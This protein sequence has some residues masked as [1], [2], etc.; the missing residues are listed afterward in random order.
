MNRK[1]YLTS[2]LLRRGA[3]PLSAWRV[4]L[5]ATAALV[6]SVSATPAASGQNRPNIAN[7]VEGVEKPKGGAPGNSKPGGEARKQ[8]T[9]RPAPGPRPTSPRQ[10][11]TLSVTFVTGQP[12]S[13]IYLRRD[14]SRLYRLG[15]TGPDGKLVTRLA[16]GPHDV[17]AS[18]LGYGMQ[19]QQVEVRPGSTTFTFNLS[20]ASTGG[21]GVAVGASVGAPA[22]A[23]EIIGRFLDPK[24]TDSLTPADW[25]RAQAQAEA[26][27]AQN[28]LEPQLEAQALFTRGQ[29]AFVGG[30][31]SGAIVAFN[32]A[33]LVM[34]N[35]ALAYYGLGNAYLAS[36]QLSESAR[37]YTRAAEL[38]PQ[39]ALAH[40]GLGDVLTRQGKSKEALAR[41]DRART[42]GYAS[43]ETSMGAARALLKGRR[44]SQALKELNEIARTKPSAEVFIGIGDCYVG[45]GQPLSAAPAYRKAVELDSKSALAHYKYGALVYEMREYAA[46]M[47]AL[48]RALALDST[49]A[50]IDRGRARDMV[51]KAAEKM[52]KMK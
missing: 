45:L 42:L 50:S 17:T 22:T 7:E 25:Q 52:R 27:Y 23:S 34:P 39:L 11:A 29:V 19:R 14:D 24:L 26:A 30:D 36:N 16:R 13:E 1:R 5:V 48:E 40:K 10:P 21:A 28:S 12:N 20:K 2:R 43:T 51:N 35:S 3:R 9:V 4:L 18:R 41:Y 38:N 47:E 6:A 31:Y 49:G 32:N 44:W 15:V 37:A 46:A 8:R 33:A